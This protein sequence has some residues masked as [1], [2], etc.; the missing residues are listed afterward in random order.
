M[1]LT[2]KRTLTAAARYT[3]ESRTKA[4]LK[5]FVCAIVPMMTGAKPPTARPVLKIKFCA[6]DLAS[7]V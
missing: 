1:S 2:K 7:V 5:P 6:V 4:V 3:A